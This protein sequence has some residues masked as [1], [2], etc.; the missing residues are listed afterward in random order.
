MSWKDRAIPAD[1]QGGWKSRA[2]PT[3]SASTAAPV[4][5]DWRSRATALAPESSSW[6]SRA[7]KMTVE[8]PLAPVAGVEA[9]KDVFS[10]VAPPFDVKADTLRSKV[11]PVLKKATVPIFDAVKFVQDRIPDSIEG[12]PLSAVGVPPRL[13][14]TPETQSDILSKVGSRLVVPSASD[15]VTMAALEGAGTGLKAA[16]P[17]FME[18]RAA[19]KASQAE[20]ESAPILREIESLKRIGERG[21]AAPPE[22]SAVDI[23]KMRAGR[24]EL[25]PTSFKEVNF[26]SEHR[27]VPDEQMLVPGIKPPKVVPKIEIQP[28]YKPRVEEQPIEEILSPPA[29]KAAD[30]GVS[31]PAEVAA[32]QG[33]LPSEV[34]GATQAAGVG[35]KTPGH[36]QTFQ[37]WLTRSGE[38]TLRKQGEAGTELANTLMKYASDREVYA[39]TRKAAFFNELMTLTPPEKDA[40]REFLDTGTVT[41]GLTPKARMIAE[42]AKGVL[43]EQG[44]FLEAFSRKHGVTVETPQGEQFFHRRQNFFPHEIDWD[45]LASPQGKAEE[46]TNL[47]NTGQAKT[48]QDAAGIVESIL[49]RRTTRLDPTDL[50]RVSGP[51]KRMAQELKGQR[52]YNLVNIVKDPVVALDN[53][54]NRIASSVARVDAF[55]KDY[56]KLYDLMTRI[57][58]EGGDA[59]SAGA[60]ALKMVGYNKEANTAVRAFLREVKGFEALKLGTAFVANAPQGFLN[61]WIRSG[62]FKAASKGFRDLF[63]RE[64][65]DFAMKAGISSRSVE[66]YIG[67]SVGALTGESGKGVMPQVSGAILEKVTP[68]KQGEVANRVVA[69]NAGKYYITESLIPK[70]LANPA[71]RRALKEMSYMG[72]DP[73][74]VLR[75]GGA[76]EQDILRASNIFAQRRT[77]FINDP[78][79]MPLLSQDPWGRLLYL[80]K[81]FSFQQS[82]MIKEAMEI[83]GVLPTVGR[84]AVASTVIGIP[85]AKLRGL[86]SAKGLTGDKEQG[87]W[88]NEFL[89]G[90][91]AIGGLGLLSDAFASA[92]FGTEGAMGSI[93]GPVVQ[94]L[95]EALVSVRKAAEGNP[96][97]GFEQ[98]L[99]RVPIVGPPTRNILKSYGLFG[100]SK[101][102]RQGRKGR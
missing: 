3:E 18:A 46:I 93:A 87:T 73:A 84:L 61:S 26:P 1:P 80:F 90:L 67:D 5:S 81:T 89:S 48:P 58:S 24:G 33:G 62:S 21:G 13:P 63:T 15:L 25:P 35:A 92:K 47:V 17:G 45:R 51:S 28:A 22:L 96:G 101:G 37:T 39:G 34:P 91:A 30:E 88:A 59:E 20:K 2:Q 97:H 82:K 31:S 55:G 72:L 74:T 44:K 10:N 95:G 4:D 42:K 98:I 56:E 71:D 6:V 11:E 38:S 23:A 79:S 7:A 102:G 32:T 78:L 36:W 60:I 53:H 40:F 57:S 52:V 99:R 68:F 69:A 70:F 14:G 94:D 54:F 66:K 86:L 43:D 12:F 41:Q 49:E 77:Q 75:Q 19:M 64:G 100:G 50:L 76:T 85:V 65:K 8:A 9:L 16:L 83:Q 27:W 29:I